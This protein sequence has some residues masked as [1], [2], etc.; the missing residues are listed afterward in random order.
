MSLGSEWHSHVF[1]MLVRAASTGPQPTGSPRR[2]GEAYNIRCLL[3]RRRCESASD[4][5]RR[6]TALR[7]VGRHGTILAMKRLYWTQPDVFETEVEVVTVGAG[8]VTTDPIFFHPDEGGQPADKGVVGE[9]T[10]NDVQVVDGKVVLTLDRPLADG[11]YAARLDKERRLYTATQHTAQHILSGIAASQ[12]GLQTV[13]VHIGLEGC[14]VDFDKKVEW[15]AAE[16][17][18][19][20]SSI[21]C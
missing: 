21:S 4:C 15:D 12:F 3:H 7:G 1:T 8:K 2:R 13:G 18:I 14:T 5:V 9:A 16:E 11:R 6:I 20:N 17:P 10:V 19:S